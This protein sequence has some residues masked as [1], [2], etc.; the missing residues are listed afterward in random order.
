MSAQVFGNLYE[1]LHIYCRVH[2]LTT[3]A[4]QHCLQTFYQRLTMETATHTAINM[5]GEVGA[6]AE[7]LWTSAQR[8]EGMGGHA[9]ELC[10]LLNSAM[11]DGHP[12]LS[13][14][15]A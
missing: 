10:S 14:P 5:M 13:G 8:F 2:D 7:L 1:L 6:T 11:R 9:K 4:Q 15:V 3:D 12:E